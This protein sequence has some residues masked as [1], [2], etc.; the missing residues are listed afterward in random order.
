MP[1]KQDI[2]NKIKELNASE[3][4]AFSISCCERMLP[5]YH[6]FST[7]EGWGD[8]KVLRNALDMLWSHLAGQEISK[9]KI[10]KMTSLVADQ[11]PE[12]ED[13]C[14]TNASRALDASAAIEL[15][16]QFADSKDESLC[17]DI[18]SL[19][20]DSVDMGIHEKADTGARTF[21]RDARVSEHELMQA[22]VSRQNEGILLAQKWNS[23]ELTLD[24]L[25]KMHK[26]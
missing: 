15:T 3:Q 20:F 14:S 8:V 5:R 16:L 13:F 12:T 10:E 6:E 25:K 21:N 26:E 4:L 9:E 2:F 22:E 18:S 11:E 17:L 24:Q 1:K 7:A 23:G 19:A